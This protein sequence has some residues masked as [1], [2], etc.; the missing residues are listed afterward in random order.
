MRWEANGRDEGGA[1][2][3]DDETTKSIVGCLLDK[4]EN[5][6]CGEERSKT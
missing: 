2:D 4:R 3:E 1:N 5:G 6:K